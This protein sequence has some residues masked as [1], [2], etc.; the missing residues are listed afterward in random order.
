M[1]LKAFRQKHPEQL[2]SGAGVVGNVLIDSTA[3]IG[4]DCQIGPNVT[5]GPG[6]VL[7]DGMFSY[8]IPTFR[9]FFFTLNMLTIYQHAGQLSSYYFV[10]VHKTGIDG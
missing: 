1:Y 6:A 5:I 2:Y 3:R 4:A 10:D 8:T 7:E 9:N